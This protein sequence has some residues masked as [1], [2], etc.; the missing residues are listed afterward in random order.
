MTVS[1]AIDPCIEPSWFSPLDG[2]PF[3]VLAIGLGWI[4]HTPFSFVFH[5][6]YAHRLE[7]GQNHLSLKLDHAFMHIA[8]GF[9]SYGTS[10]RWEYCLLNFIMNFDF[11]WR[12][13]FHD[14]VEERSNIIRVVISGLMGQILPILF[15]GQWV[16]GLQLSLVYGVGGWMFA[17]Y[18]LGLW[19]HSIFHLVLVFAP[20][21][22]MS[23]SLHLP[24]NEE[25]IKQA[26]EC[27]VHHG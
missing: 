20:Y 27:A 18:P 17:A 8:S 13:L 12:H 25:I 24:G 5:W 26:A 19:S 1:E 23:A 9:I 2:I 14:K 15:H 6:M 16:L 10:G 7:V 4:M 11:A 22:M 21:I 3:S